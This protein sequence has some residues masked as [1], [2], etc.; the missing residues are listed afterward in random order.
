MFISSATP[1]F[2]L[3]RVKPSLLTGEKKKLATPS[4]TEVAHTVCSAAQASSRV[5][6]DE[7]S[8]TIGI[9]D[10]KLGGNRERHLEIEMLFKKG[11]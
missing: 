5:S 7:E 8:C 11:L 4:V 1:A 10:F 3:P 9:G 2:N 6:S